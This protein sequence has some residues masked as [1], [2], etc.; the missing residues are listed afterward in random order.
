[1]YLN[2]PIEPAKFM[3]Q[4]RKLSSPVP[5]FCK[6][7]TRFSNSAPIKC[8]KTSNSSSSGPEYCNLA[9]QAYT[10]QADCCPR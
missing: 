1:M 2:L 4:V 10:T 3:K 7:W 9:I 5:L 8:Q 6:V